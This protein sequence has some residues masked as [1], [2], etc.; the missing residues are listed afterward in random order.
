VSDIDSIADRTAAGIA[1]A[2]RSAETSPVEV[3]ECLL[4][5]IANAQSEN[6]FISVAADRARAEA[7]AA[8][9]R[10][11]AGRPLSALDGVPIAWKDVFDVAGTRTTAG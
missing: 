9:A 2:Y 8:D 5:R 4:D 11:K 10:Y 6:A 3:T 1:L 7:A